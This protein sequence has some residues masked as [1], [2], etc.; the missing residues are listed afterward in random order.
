[1]HSAV[2]NTIAALSDGHIV[3]IRLAGMFVV[4]VG[5]VLAGCIAGNRFGVSERW[6]KIIMT[7]VLIFLEWLIA[8]LIIWQIPLSRDLVWLP[9]IGIVM[10]LGIT[11]G[12]ATIFSLFKLDH[13]SRLTLILAG[14]LSNLGY[15]GGAFVCFALFG[16]QGL[17]LAN[18]YSVLWM[19]TAC[20]VFFPLLKI[21]ELRLS[22]SAEKFKPIE[23][24]DPRMLSLPATI[25]ALILNFKG[26]KQPDFITDFHIVDIFVYTASSLSFFAIGLRVNFSRIKNY[27]NLYFPLA[28]V[29]F[30]LTPL[31]ALVLLWL[32]T[33]TGHDL[34]NLVKKVVIVLSACPSAVLMVT[35]SNVFDLDGPLASAL[36]VATT[37]IFI[38]IVVPILFFVLA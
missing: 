32:L 36:W 4:L 10:M 31:V 24:L 18:I 1:M 22:G 27:I 11:T 16:T 17:G 26:I 25:I 8:L 30:L 19:P 33:L 34:T 15:T 14:G 20:L 7:A 3:N 38:A 29:K 12:S 2:S 35:M 37:V 13:K 28:A 21:R 9:I 5:G 23:L 6:A